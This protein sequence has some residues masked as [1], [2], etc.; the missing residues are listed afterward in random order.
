MQ[1]RQKWH[2]TLDRSFPATVN[3]RNEAMMKEAGDF[4]LSLRRC[5]KDIR[6][7]KEATEGAPVRNLPKAFL[8]NNQIMFP[9]GRDCPDYRGASANTISML[10]PRDDKHHGDCVGI[11]FCSEQCSGGAMMC[12][13][14]SADQGL[15]SPRSELRHAVLAG[16]LTTTRL[17]MSQ[18]LPRIYDDNGNGKVV[19]Q[20]QNDADGANLIGGDFR[21]EDLQRISRET[22]RRCRAE[23]CPWCKRCLQFVGAGT[24][25]RKEI[26]IFR[27]PLWMACQCEAAFEYTMQADLML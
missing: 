25:R 4:A 13:C 19:A 21:M 1:A 20:A 12:R 3:H 10:H 18:P 8:T 26:G 22:V 2:L 9:S 7:L 11:R 27:Q 17:V 15:V 6:T 24:C 5:E 23:L 16:L 14:L